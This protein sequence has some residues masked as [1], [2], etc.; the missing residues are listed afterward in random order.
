MEA[1]NRGARAADIYAEVAKKL[2]TR[3]DPYLRIASEISS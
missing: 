1:L 3:I 2:N